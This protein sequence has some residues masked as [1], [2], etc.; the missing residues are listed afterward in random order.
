[1]KVVLITLL[2]LNVIS[3]FS[4]E[5]EGSAVF[6]H[7]IMGNS[8]GYAQSN[9]EADMTAAQHLGI[10]GFA[11]NIGEDDWTWDRLYKAYMA[12]EAVGFKVFISFDM[13]N[14]ND[15]TQPWD[16]INWIH[17]FGGYSSQYTYNGKIFVSTFAGE[18]VTLGQSSPN[19]GWQYVKDNLASSWGQ[20]MYFCPEWSGYSSPSTV[21][22]DNSAIDC[23]FSWN[24]WPGPT[25]N[26]ATLQG[27][28]N[29]YISQKGSRQYMA[30]VSPYFFTHLSYKNYMYKTETL[31]IDRWQTLLQTQP[32][33]IQIVTWNDWGESH[34]IGT[35]D[36]NSN[37]LPAGS[38]AYVYGF[39]HEPFQDILPAF[40][41]AYKGGR[42]TPD[43]TEDIV[44][45]WH[46]ANFVTGAN[47]SDGL[48]PPTIQNRDTTPSSYTISQVLGNE[49]FVAAL[50]V[51]PAQVSI[52]N[53]D[54]TSNAWTYSFGAGTTMLNS[55]IMTNWGNFQVSLI[56]N[57][58]LLDT[59]Y[60]AVGVVSS[61][62]TCNFNAY[63]NRV[64]SATP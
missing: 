16:I 64:T 55:F 8:Y 30:P 36:T 61:G 14:S 22:Q 33:F 32:D 19:A 40:I 39:T 20:Q 13:S 25:E 54:D 47:C 57:G 52:V 12:A 9:F 41:S 56:R 62:G 46:R 53:E 59:A 11:L 2:L 4:V 29:S 23:F 42:T 43:I 26:A 63:A 34:Y 45:Y 48:G 17:S 38:P 6:A 49:L 1:M 18:T 58:V 27:V 5:V 7:F 44:I 3:L 35:I 24:A 51:S 60:D 21:Y 28:D 37:D 50:L 10:D 15:F 31:W